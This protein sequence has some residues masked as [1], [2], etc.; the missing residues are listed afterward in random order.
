MD[1]LRESDSTT[2]RGAVAGL[3]RAACVAEAPGGCLRRPEV[4]RGSA[5]G[6]IASHSATT[7][8]PP[9]CAGR[10]MSGGALPRMSGTAYAAMEVELGAASVSQAPAAPTPV[11]EVAVFRAV[12]AKN[13]ALKWRGLICCCSGAP[14]AACGPACSC[15]PDCVAST[16]LEIVVPLVFLGLLCL[17]RYLIADTQFPERLFAPTNMTSLAWSSVRQL[18]SRRACLLS[19]SDARLAASAV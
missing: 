8:V 4:T 7:V 9:T 10:M 11:S 14:A 17:P 6:W 18:S 13:W 15:H 12:L 2:S 19:G 5:S 3:E 16:A 1:K